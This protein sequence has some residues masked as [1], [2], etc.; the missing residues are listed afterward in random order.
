MENNEAEFD[1]LV[2]RS[3][4]ELPEVYRDA[5]QSLGIRTEAQASSEVM[6]ALDVTNPN[7]LLG[8]YHGVNLTQKSV[9]DLPS[10]PDEV[11]IYRNLI[12]AYARNRSSLGRGGQACPCSRDRASFWLLGRRH[13]IDRTGLRLSDLKGY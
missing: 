12:L 5:C 7:E 6:V 10:L 3:F 9:F 2:R 13:G 4:E 1:A 8:L 11:I